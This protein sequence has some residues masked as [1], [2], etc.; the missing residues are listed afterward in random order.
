M[1]AYLDRH[2]QDPERRRARL[3]HIA[4]ELLRPRT[5]GELGEWLTK[6]LR[7]AVGATACTILLRRADW[8][9]WKV[10]GKPGRLPD[11][12]DLEALTSGSPGDSGSA[13]AGEDLLLA[14]PG[15]DSLIGALWVE[16]GRDLDR[17]SG[18]LVKAIA[19]TAGVFLEQA[20]GVEELNRDVLTGLLTASAFNRRADEV[21][22]RDRSVDSVLLLIAFQVAGKEAISAAYGPRAAKAAVADLATAVK[23]TLPD[24]ALLGVRFDDITAICGPIDE[25]GAQIEANQ[26]ARAVD[27]TLR[28]SAAAGSTLAATAAYLVIRQSVVDLAEETKRLAGKLG[29]APAGAAVRLT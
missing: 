13:R 21:V 6:Q 9:P 25:A 16:A 23:K 14:I 4:R 12:S 20:L 15:V 28:N 29:G 8:A 3:G 5:A 22:A 19:D 18:A 17:L 11:T 1:R 27:T 2:I 26:I 10:A 7:E 24:N